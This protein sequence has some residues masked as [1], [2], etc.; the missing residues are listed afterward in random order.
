MA[1]RPVTH[2]SA[3]RL[4]AYGQGKLDAASGHLDALGG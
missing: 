4:Q 2:P 1:T 3:D